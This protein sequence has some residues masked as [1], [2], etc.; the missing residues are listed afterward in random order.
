VAGFSENVVCNCKQFL[1]NAL[2]NGSGYC[3]RHP[4]LFGTGI[5]LGIAGVGSVVLCAA[6]G[7]ANSEFISLALFY[8]ALKPYSIFMIF[9]V[10]DSSSYHAYS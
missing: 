10:W 1:F 6:A 2:K 9:S 8:L 5:S 4:K 3:I 7:N